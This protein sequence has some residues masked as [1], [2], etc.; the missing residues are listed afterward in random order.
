MQ[1]F[2]HLL[3][4]SSQPILKDVLQSQ[5]AMNEYWVFI[6]GIFLLLLSP[7]PTNALLAVG[8][9]QRGF[10]RSLPLLAAAFFGYAV[11]ILVIHL[12][13]QPIL[14]AF[15]GISL[16]CKLVFAAFVFYLVVKLWRSST[17][18]GATSGAVDF[19]SMFITTSLNPKAFGFALVLIPF[20]SPAIAAYL[21]LFGVF[22]L[23]T[24]AIWVAIGTFTTHMFGSGAQMFVA[25][26][27][28]IVMCLFACA[29]VYL[30]IS[31]L[32]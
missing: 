6:S 10:M 25:R 31:V 19:R 14:I 28:A 9:S 3:G 11:A 29:I 22:V 20:E 26:I 5:L 32:P 7:G 18:M 15:P 24:G 8:G 17:V 23:V 4:N 27:A 12:V 2:D 30:T 21:G 16:F 13:L 1:A